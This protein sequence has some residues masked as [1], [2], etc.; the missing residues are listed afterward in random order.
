M[1]LQAD[2][3][4]GIVEV[5]EFD[6]DVDVCEMENFYHQLPSNTD[7]NIL[8]CEVYIDDIGHRDMLDDM[9]DSY[10]VKFLKGLK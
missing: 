3:Y 7:D 5:E 1:K 10:G 9:I 2:N 8:A 6:Y 4:N